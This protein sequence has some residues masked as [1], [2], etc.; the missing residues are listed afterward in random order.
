MVTRKKGPVKGVRIPVKLPWK[1]VAHDDEQFV[2]MKAP[3]ANFLELQAADEK[4]LTY[5]GKILYKERNDDGKPVGSLKSKEVTKTRIPGYRA[6]SIKVIFGDRGTG[7]RETFNG[8]DKIARSSISFPVTKS[9]SIT[10]IRQEFITGK[11]K[12]KPVVRIEDVNSG[13]G[14]PIY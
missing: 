6:R 14:Y 1:G 7:Q 11:W 10:E 13:Q 9:I 12:N 2:S 8:V 3:V 4:D 5:K